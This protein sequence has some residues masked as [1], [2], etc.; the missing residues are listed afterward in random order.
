MPGNAVQSRGERS[1]RAPRQIA[2]REQ[3]FNERE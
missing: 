3:K 2:K 1:E